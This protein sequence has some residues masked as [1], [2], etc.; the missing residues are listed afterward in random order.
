MSCCVNLLLLNCYSSTEC[1]YAG[2]RACV[3]VCASDGASVS[4]TVYGG[5]KLEFRHK[6]Y[7]IRLFLDSILNIRYNNIITIITTTTTAPRPP[8]TTIKTTMSPLSKSKLCTQI[9]SYNR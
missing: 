4:K 7:I 8:I 5:I 9:A 1:A 6:N 3:R 2:A